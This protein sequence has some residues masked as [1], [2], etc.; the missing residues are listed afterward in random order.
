[1]LEECSDSGETGVLMTLADDEIKAI[2]MDIAKDNRIPVEGVS[3]RPDIDSAG[4]AAIEIVI[5]IAPGI[6]PASIGD[7]ST[8][9]T[10]EVVRKLADMGE[11]RLPIV[12]YE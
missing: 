7:Q 1:V 4:L 5:S 8:R 6:S 10:S 2:V 9:T 12:W 11:E 3:T